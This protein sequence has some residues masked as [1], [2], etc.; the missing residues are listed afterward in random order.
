MRYP[1]TLRVLCLYRTSCLS[2]RPCHI[3]LKAPLL[4]DDYLEDLHAAFSP[5]SHNVAFLHLRANKTVVINA[6]FFISGFV[7]NKLDS[8]RTNFREE[9][10]RKPYGLTLQ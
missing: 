2:S 5:H 6:K 8:T 9:I 3:N 1:R 4:R 7:Q 10:I